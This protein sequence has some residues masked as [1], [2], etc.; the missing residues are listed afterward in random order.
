MAGSSVDREIRITASDSGV[1]D[2]L[3]KMKEGALA[4]GRGIAEDAKKQATSSREL[5]KL[6]NDEIALIEKRNKLN[7]ASRETNA[8]SKLAD[9]GD[10]QS[11]SK[12]MQKISVEG[13]DDKIQSDLLKQILQALL[14]TSQEEVTANRDSVKSQIASDKQIDA[15]EDHEEAL[16]Q[17]FTKQV[18]QDT[19]PEGDETPGEAQE[20]AKSTIHG[21]GNFVRETDVYTMGLGGGGDFLKSRASGV[22]NKLGKRALLAGGIILG[23]LGMTISAASDRME[24]YGDVFRASGGGGYGAVKD[25]T[26][27]QAN[28]RAAQLNL[29]G[30]ERM[31]GSHMS[32]LLKYERSQG[33]NSENLA[34]FRRFGGEDNE[35]GANDPRLMMGMFKS[36]MKDFNMNKS[37]TNDLLEASLSLQEAEYMATGTASGMLNAAI[38]NRL[39]SGQE[40][41]DAKRAS[42]T[43]GRLGG[44]IEGGNEQLEAIKFSE[45]QKKTGGN[46]GDYLKEKEKG[47]SGIIDDVVIDRILSSD[48]SKYDKQLSMY[49]TGLSWTDTEEIIKAGGVGPLATQNMGK[50]GQG[51]FSKVLAEGQAAEA[52][53]SNRVT[54]SAAWVTDGFAS[55]GEAAIDLVDTLIS[56][57][58]AIGNMF[59]GDGATTTNGSGGQTNTVHQ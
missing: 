48:M 21:M 44:M 54:A 31:S 11:Y 22:E 6:M 36:I 46:F 32:T 26:T 50:D 24:G 33:I 37:R 1:F 40:S 17:M 29:A 42:A 9:T 2:K 3:M 20:R 13:K 45:F 38:L 25:M 59:S 28:T 51:G 16:K 47:V 56:A 4:M 19:E 55:V 10:K 8:Q 58:Q 12:E 57:G 5:I 52:G 15:N 35:T 53:G 49:S 30:G 39:M 27:A 41:P 43:A 23:G 18:I 14:K 7:Q 34:K